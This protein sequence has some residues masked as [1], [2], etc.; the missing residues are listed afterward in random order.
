M[1]S[2]IPNVIGLCAIQPDNAV[3]KVMSIPDNRCIRVVIP[4][5]H[6]PNGY[7]EIPIH[8]MEEEDPLFVA[9]SD[10]GCLQSGLA[11]GLIYVYGTL[12]VGSRTVAPVSA[13]SASDP[14]NPD[15]VHSVAS[16]FSKI[17]AD[18][19]PVLTWIWHNYGGAQ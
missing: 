11:E 19:S 2:D 16:T 5:D 3:I 10:L 8:D 6:V 17:W 1:D 4:D 12:S 7:H 9:L 13:G 14:H 18:M 15:C